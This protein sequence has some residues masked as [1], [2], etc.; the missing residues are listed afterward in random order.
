MKVSNRIKV[1]K[2]HPIK[3]GW[4]LKLLS[5]V[6]LG[7][8]ASSAGHTTDLEIYQGATY[9]N[10]SIMMMLDNSGSMGTGSISSD[11]S[12]VSS[13]DRTSSE[14]LKQ[15]LYDDKGM[16]T[17]QFYEYEVEY[18]SKNSTRYYDRMSRLKMALM[19][20]FANP[21]S[22]QAFG[23]DADLSKYKIGLGSFY[24]EYDNNQRSWQDGGKITN[25]VV[26]LTIDNRKKILEVV[27]SLSASTNTPTANAY[28]E[29]G[30][31]ML[32]TNTQKTETE[33]VY[34]PVGA[35]EHRSNN[36]KKYYL[37]NCSNVSST[38]FTNNGNTHFYC[39]N[40]SNIGPN[41]G[42]KTLLELSLND[43][44]TYDL[45]KNITI[46]SEN[47][48]LTYYYRA[49]TREVVSNSASGFSQSSDDTKVKPGLSKYDSPI[50]GDANQC[51]GYGV[52]FLTDGE[53][54]TSTTDTINLMENSLAGSSLSMGSLCDSGLTSTGTTFGA[55]LDGSVSVST[56]NIYITKAI[57]KVLLLQR[58]LWAL[59][60]Y[61][62]N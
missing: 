24:R 32:G 50:K 17:S 37:Y 23:K 43:L 54:N 42:A 26:N 30:A 5:T 22:D 49:Q 58:Q 41:N 39:N 57:L 15:Y 28:A 35:V 60:V 53:P 62:K 36:N 6:I 25:P 21:K 3:T 1:N 29:A 14:K 59:A 45:S 20:M 52:Y 31:Y 40:L 46:P 47:G 48:T 19:P 55:A 27:R 38:T 4:S 11:Y 12:A 18:V 61:L 16:I 2:A 51:D 34:T 7:S 9:G 13:R 44:G 10:A 8:M 33:T 56:L